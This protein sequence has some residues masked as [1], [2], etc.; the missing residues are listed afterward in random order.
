MGAEI[1]KIPA[2]RNPG[3]IK[4]LDTSLSRPSLSYVSFSKSQVPSQNSI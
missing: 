3:F 4:K 1:A 2:M